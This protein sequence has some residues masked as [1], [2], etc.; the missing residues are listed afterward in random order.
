[1]TSVASEMTN[2]TTNDEVRYEEVKYHYPDLKKEGPKLTLQELYKIR[3]SGERIDAKLISNLIELFT[4]PPEYVE[5]AIKER[6]EFDDRLE[7]FNQ[8]RRNHNE[9]LKAEL[10]RKTAEARRTGSNSKYIIC[11]GQVKELK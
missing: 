6:Q 7:K 11:D 10:K 5:L 3:K 8:E 2:P 9:C 1:M 4:P